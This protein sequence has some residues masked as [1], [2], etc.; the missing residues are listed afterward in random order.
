MG[1]AEAGER[2]V[3]EQIGAKGWNTRGYLPHFDQPG[4]MQMLTFRLGDAMPAALRHEWERLYEIKDERERRTKLEAYLDRGLGECQLR[5]AKCAAAFE[6]VLLKFDGAHYRLAAWVMMP[7]HVHVLVELWTMPLGRLCKAWKGASA[8]AINHILR[9]SG[10]FW[11]EDYWDRYIRD[12]E[13]FRKA[14]RYIELNPIKA[15]LSGTAADWPHGSAN[16]K[17]RWVGTCRF[18]GGHLAGGRWKQRRS[19]SPPWTAL[20]IEGKG[21]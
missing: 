3:E 11:Q 4:T 5:N 10:E 2:W 7:N 12:E 14:L 21:Q 18:F 20:P 19:D 13:H 16:P 6:E 8:N 17:W 15:G 9:R 1:P